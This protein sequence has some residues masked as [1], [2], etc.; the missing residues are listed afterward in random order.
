VNAIPDKFAQWDAAAGSRASGLHAP[1]DAPI[2]RAP[3]SRI[4]IFIS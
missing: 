3:G 4:A 1:Y 2:R